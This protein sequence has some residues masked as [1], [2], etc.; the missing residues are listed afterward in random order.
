MNEFEWQKQSGVYAWLQAMDLRIQELGG[1]GVFR[2]L[3]NLFNAFQALFD[4]SGKNRLEI[5]YVIIERTRRISEVSQEL[6]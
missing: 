2:F 3:D 1:Y 4:A 6:N 5:D